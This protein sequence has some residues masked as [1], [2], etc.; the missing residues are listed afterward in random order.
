MKISKLI[1]GELSTN[2]YLFESKGELAIIDAGDEADRII[3]EAKAVKAKLKYLIC[4][5]YHYDHVEAVEEVKKEL[6]GVVILH[7]AEKEYL[8]F[9]VDIFLKNGD[10]IILGDETITI[11]N[12]PG[13]SEG[14]ICLLGK[15]YLFTGDLLFANGFGHTILPG[16]SDIKIKNSL[17]DIRQIIKPGMK[18][19]PGHGE[20]F[21]A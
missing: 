7:E 4:T 21:I 8:D 6:G 13:H 15:D 10:K 17:A 3:A 12:L 11:Y 20:S 16:G 19:Y 5:H 1:V 9:P 14:S 18:I 2:C